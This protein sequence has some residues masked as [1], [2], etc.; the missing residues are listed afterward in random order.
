MIVDPSVDGIPDEPPELAGVLQTFRRQH[1]S[2][3]NCSS[4]KMAYRLQN[5]CLASGKNTGGSLDWGELFHSNAPA[6][7]IILRGSLVYWA[8]FLLFRFVLRRNVGS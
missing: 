1:R 6:L 4:A 7:E 3:A 8:L 5:L 2:A